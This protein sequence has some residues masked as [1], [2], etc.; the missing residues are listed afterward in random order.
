M[1]LPVHD[2]KSKIDIMSLTGLIG[3][4]KENKP[5]L[6]LNVLTPGMIR[7][8]VKSKISKEEK[9]DLIANA[10]DR[11]K[12]ANVLLRITKYAGPADAYVKSIAETIETLDPVVY[13]KL[14]LCFALDIFQSEKHF[15]RKKELSA[16]VRKF[17]PVLTRDI[18]ASLAKMHV[19]EFADDY[20]ASGGR[21]HGIDVLQEG[22][23]H[24]LQPKP[25]Q[26]QP[27][28]QQLVPIVDKRSVIERNWKNVLLILQFAMIVKLCFGQP[29]QFFCINGS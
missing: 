26:Q 28:Q 8:V 2:H 25:A 29:H 15:D 6:W 22:S 27:A 13:S 11:Q 14:A 4:L 9:L 3:V 18:V 7:T 12:V 21:L 5:S 19:T 17:S 20:K 1:H 24:K 16:M 10:E 23:G